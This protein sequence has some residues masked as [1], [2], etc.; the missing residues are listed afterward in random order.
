M[1][2]NYDQKHLQNNLNRSRL[3]YKYR[4]KFLLHGDDL[5]KHV[6]DIK[7]K[8]RNHNVRQMAN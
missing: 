5:I 8:I 7:V 2:L 1:K 4:L 6:I 3:P